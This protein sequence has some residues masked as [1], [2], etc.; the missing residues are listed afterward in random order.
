MLVA[1]LFG[2]W[3]VLAAFFTPSPITALMGSLARNGDG[4]LAAFLFV[5]VFVFVYLQVKTRPVVLERILLGIVLSGLILSF[6]A[7]AEVALGR[8]LIY[9]PN[10]ADLPIV[11]FPQRGHLAGYL[12]ATLGVS[13]AVSFWKRAWFYPV[14]S[15]FIACALGLT[16]NRA[17]FLA[18]LVLVALGFRLYPK[19]AVLMALSVGLGIL[20]G[21]GFTELRGVGGDKDLASR[22][23]LQSRFL[24]WKAAIGGI[25]ER[26]MFGWGG[27]NFDYYW[28]FFLTPEEQAL[29]FKYEVGE[30]KVI[31]ILSQPGTIPVWLVETPSGERRPHS[32]PLW[33]SHN[34][35]ME[36]A[37]QRGLV[38]LLL[39]LALMAFSLRAFINL[40]PGA[41][42]V[43]GYHVFLMLWFIPFFSEGVL[44]VLFALSCVE[45]ERAWGFIPQAGLVPRSRDLAAAGNPYV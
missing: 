34:Q 23:S 32:I 33:K 3:G 42:G 43:W 31:E 19:R 11:S 40:L 1:L 44:W 37:L 4:A 10:P 2:V 22:T 39:Y 45:G 12:A 15:F 7:V 41:A 27:G 38:G 6:G 25:L 20:G 13:I 17:A 18:V 5:L 9:R 30:L 36:V 29:F 8:G 28:P 16:F 35:L 21:M 26:P 14:A 24:F